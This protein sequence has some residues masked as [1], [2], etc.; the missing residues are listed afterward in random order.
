MRAT[1]SARMLGALSDGRRWSTSELY[2]LHLTPHSRKS[3]LA[4]L[5]YTVSVGREQQWVAGE[6][7]IY[8]YRLEAVPAVAPPLEEQ[9][10]DGARAA[11]DRMRF[12]GRAGVPANDAGVSERGRPGRGS[13]RPPVDRD[14]E[15]APPTGAPAG[16]VR[17][18]P[19]APFVASG[20]GAPPGWVVVL[21]SDVLLEELAGIE[22][23]LAVLASEV[24]TFEDG[25]LLE[26]LEARRDEILRL[27][28]SGVRAVGSLA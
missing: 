27:W 1:D 4:K 20:T 23:Q 28:S 9:L 11:I 22:G 21:P 15:A 5:G 7:A 19:A 18:A 8:W 13:S 25:E 2:G 14:N 10:E 24:L 3:D 26:E 16:A 6:K 12:A 17:A